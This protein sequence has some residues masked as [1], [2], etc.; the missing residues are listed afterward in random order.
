MLT[1]LRSFSLAIFV[2]LVFVIF[3]YVLEKDYY[4]LPKVIDSTI[5]FSLFLYFSVAINFSW[6]LYKFLSRIHDLV[7]F[8]VELSKLEELSNF[9]FKLLVI[10]TLLSVN[11]ICTVIFQVTDLDDH[12]RVI[13][14]YV[15]FA[16]WPFI[17]FIMIEL[18]NCLDKHFNH[19]KGN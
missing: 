17:L 1:K 15:A 18:G 7:S 11:L 2:T 5:N 16:T 10:N 12:F 6:V 8:I 13:A 14:M 3:V 4:A 9:Y 19:K